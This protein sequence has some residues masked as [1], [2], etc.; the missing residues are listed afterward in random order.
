MYE[1]KHTYDFSN[2]I[3]SAPTVDAVPVIRC[4]YCR[5][6]DDFRKWCDQHGIGFD[7][8]NAETWFCADGEEKPCDI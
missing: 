2:Q 4:R 8:R 1:R 6:Y 5:H 7:V 3:K